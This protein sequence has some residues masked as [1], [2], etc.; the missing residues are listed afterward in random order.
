MCACI[1]VVCAVFEEYFINVSM[2]DWCLVHSH[3]RHMNAVSE[4]AAQC[5]YVRKRQTMGKMRML[6]IGW[7]SGARVTIAAIQGICLS[8]ALDFSRPC[9]IGT[10]NA[11]EADGLSI[12]DL[13]SILASPVLPDTVTNLTKRLAS[14]ALDDTPAQPAPSVNEPAPTQ[15]SS[16]A[17]DID[18]YQQWL[19]EAQNNIHHQALDHA[20]QL[21]RASRPDVV[22]L[23]PAQSSHQCEKRLT[24]AVYHRNAGE[25]QMFRKNIP[26]KRPSHATHNAG[27]SGVMVPYMNHGRPMPCQL[28]RLTTLIYRNGHQCVIDND[29]RVRLCELSD[30]EDLHRRA[31]ETWRDDTLYMCNTSG[32]AHR[33]GS[34]CRV[35]VMISDTQY[36]YTCPITGLSDASRCLEVSSF[37]T[38]ENETQGA[39]ESSNGSNSASGSGGSG[40]ASSENA[41]GGKGS[42]GSSGY[43]T[44][45]PE[46]LRLRQMF[47]RDG[48]L[49]RHGET[50]MHQ[51]NH[52]DACHDWVQ[53]L[54]ARRNRMEIE[55]YAHDYIRATMRSNRPIAYLIVA[56]CDLW[57]LLCPER[58]TLEL[59]R[60]YHA[61]NAALEYAQRN[62]AEQ[63]WQHRAPG[64]G[65][66][67]GKARAPMSLL[68]MDSCYYAHVARV[69]IPVLPSV[70]ECTGFLVSHAHAL[71]QLW[72]VLH[73]R[74][75]PT[76]A[77]S[78]SAAK[79]T[80][81]S[82]PKGAIA[83]AKF[84]IPALSLL[85][86][87]VIRPALFDG[88]LDQVLVAPQRALLMILPEASVLH[89]LCGGTTEAQSR[90]LSLD[91]EHAMIHAVRQGRCTAEQLDFAQVSFERM[92]ASRFYSLDLR[93]R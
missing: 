25:E 59:R 24:L 74:V 45:S 6:P 5:S 67:Q 9:A 92:D 48:S 76:A 72:Y 26:R 2:N 51:L 19:D 41:S 49:R 16:V 31:L 33:C 18:S 91:M 7:L 88:E 29:R 12:D 73:T 34:H 69:N 71:V 32:W 55:S 39:S 56:M 11:I 79:P 38:P 46:D 62:Y 57:L 60:L 27:Q 64:V 3:A 53:Q 15:T 84:A 13:D 70:S 85:A 83:F 75:L 82:P 47:T 86:R 50:L 23:S 89:A 37:W 36:C 14:E 20:V 93:E 90:A 63:Q 44:P 4:P 54:V 40:S 42:S 30:R 52:H 21:W 81:P 65:D 1:V 17:L 43:G 78:C 77:V 87:G 58:R 8:G 35:S 10:R 66:G 61:H 22:L 80:T 28:T 68:N